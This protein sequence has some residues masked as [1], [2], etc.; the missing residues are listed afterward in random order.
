[1][2]RSS[3]SPTT[4]AHGLIDV[5]LVGE[6]PLERAC[7]AEALA[8]LEHEHRA[9]RPRE[10]GR[11]VSPL[12][13]PPTTIASQRRAGELRDRLGQADLAQARRDLVRGK[14]AIAAHA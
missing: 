4:Y 14:R 11:A 1:M 2:T 6:R 10:V 13:P 9:A 8:P 3:S 5:P 7:A 12:W